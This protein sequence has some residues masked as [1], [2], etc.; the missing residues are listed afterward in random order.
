MGGNDQKTEIVAGKK[1]ERWR[2]QR[3]ERKGVAR[4]K[5]KQPEGGGRRQKRRRGMEE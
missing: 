5:W 4:I 3:R 1:K 2:R